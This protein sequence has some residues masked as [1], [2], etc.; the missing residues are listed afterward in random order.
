MQCID[1]T[2]CNV[3]LQDMGC[4]KK[5]G[6]RAKCPMNKPKM[7]ANR[8]CDDKTDVCCGEWNWDCGYQHGTYYGGPLQCDEAFSSKLFSIG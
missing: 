3:S 8:E 6:G 1:G 7:C 5:H 2:D 4:C